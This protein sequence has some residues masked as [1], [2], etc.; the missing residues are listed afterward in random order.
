MFSEKHPHHRV[1]AIIRDIIQVLFRT[2]GDVSRSFGA[3]LRIAMGRTCSN[4]T[5]IVPQPIARPL[6]VKRDRHDHAADKR[7]TKGSS[8]KT[9]SSS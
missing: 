3:S 4:D 1:E 2:T 6:K 5:A 9:K 7:E 8:G